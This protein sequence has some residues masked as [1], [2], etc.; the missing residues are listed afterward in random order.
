[1]NSDL[2]AAPHPDP[3]PSAGR[4]EIASLAAM[5]RNTPVSPFS[6][7]QRIPA[8]SNVFFLEPIS[9]TTESQ[10]KSMHRS[11]RSEQSFSRLSLL[12]RVGSIWLCALVT[13]L[14]KPGKMI[15]RT[16]PAKCKESNSASWQSTTCKVRRSQLHLESI[17]GLMGW[18]RLVRWR[19]AVATPWFFRS[20][21]IESV[22]SRQ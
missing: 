10:R 17:V 19:Q 3:L 14:V 12:P 20:L 5:W 8:Y 18:R 7:F 15:K 9:W 1:M 4:R 16:H 11:K 2:K 6:L 21:T 22:V 13:W